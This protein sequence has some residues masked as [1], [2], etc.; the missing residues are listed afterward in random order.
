M[1]VPYFSISGTDFLELFF[2]FF[3]PDFLHTFQYVKMLPKKKN[4]G[5]KNAKNYLQYFSI[6]V[7]SPTH[8]Y[9]M[10]PASPN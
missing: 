5:R 2:L 8:V 10:L 9:K 4:Q 6:L 1:I 7:F 3:V